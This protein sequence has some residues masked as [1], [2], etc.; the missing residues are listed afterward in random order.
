MLSCNFRFLTYFWRAFLRR[1]H[2][3]SSYYENLRI[4]IVQGS[5]FWLIYKEF[6]RKIAISDLFALRK[7]RTKCNQLSPVYIHRKYHNF[8]PVKFHKTNS[9]QWNFNVRKRTEKKK[10]KLQDQRFKTDGKLEKPFGLVR[11]KIYYFL[12]EK[13]VLCVL[14]FYFSRTKEKKIYLFAH[15]YLQNQINYLHIKYVLWAS[16]FV[17]KRAFEW[18]IWEF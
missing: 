15:M 17:V 3:S 2:L 5:N 14:T 12:Q 10:E 7:V 11:W 9:K 8:S 4:E 16:F 1:L 18:D 6:L 13:I